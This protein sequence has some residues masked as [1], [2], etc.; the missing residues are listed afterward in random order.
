MRHVN[1]HS[2]LLTYPGL[3]YRL[4]VSLS[5]LGCPLTM[6]LSSSS[7]R[8]HKSSNDARSRCSPKPLAS[9]LGVCLTSPNLHPSVFLLD[10]VRELLRKLL[11]ERA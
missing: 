3:V 8:F 10:R 6:A 5:Y 4:Y 2:S 9:S 7:I 11:F 1:R